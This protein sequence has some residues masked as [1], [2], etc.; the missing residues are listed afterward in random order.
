M[1]AAASA[2]S[3]QI[4]APLP[5]AADWGDNIFAACTQASIEKSGG[6]VTM[7]FVDGVLWTHCSQVLG[8]LALADR[9]ALKSEWTGIHL[10]H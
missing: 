3:K 2:F 4:H 1:R 10:S 8:D 9:Q 6:V 5:R 7:A